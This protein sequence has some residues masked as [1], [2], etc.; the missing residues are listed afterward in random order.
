MKVFA[1]RTCCKMCQNLVKFGASCFR[2]MCIFAPNL[3]IGGRWGWWLR[4]KGEWIN[5]NG[6]WLHMWQNVTKLHQKFAVEF[7]C[8]SN[9]ATHRCNIGS[10]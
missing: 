6:V 8:K 4:G 1:P 9:F 3:T 7:W 5:G 10:F 2:Q